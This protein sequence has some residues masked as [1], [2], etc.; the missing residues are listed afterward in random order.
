MRRKW[1]VYSG[2]YHIHPT[3]VKSKK[4]KVKN[5]QTVLLLLFF[6]SIVG[7][8]NYKHSSHPCS[9][10]NGGC[11][12]MCLTHPDSSTGLLKASC[13]CP[14]GKTVMADGKTCHSGRV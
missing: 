12:Y 1:K 9:H 13:Q 5:E 3:L 11:D 14:G 10:G 8:R 6:L 7:G 2:A 4:C